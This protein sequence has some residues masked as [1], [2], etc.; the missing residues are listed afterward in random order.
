MSPPPIYVIY[1]FIYFFAGGQWMYNAALI[2]DGKPGVESEA[3][4]ALR[5]LLLWSQSDEL[6]SKKYH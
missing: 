4:R 6:D 2:I 5:K 1:L 3:S